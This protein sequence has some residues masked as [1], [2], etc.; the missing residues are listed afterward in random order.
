M[1]I[2]LKDNRMIFI[3]SSI[4]IAFV[5]VCYVA[6]QW[7][8][9]RWDVAPFVFAE[10]DESNIQRIQSFNDVYIG[11]DDPSGRS[12]ELVEQ[13]ETFEDLVFDHPFTKYDEYDTAKLKRYFNKATGDRKTEI[14][15][16][17][18]DQFD[19]AHDFMIRLMELYGDNKLPF[20]KGSEPYLF[21][22]KMVNS[23]TQFVEEVEDPFMIQAFHDLEQRITEAQQQRESDP[24][25]IKQDNAYKRALELVEQIESEINA[26]GYD[27]DNVSTNMPW[28]ISKEDQGHS[29][30]DDNEKAESSAVFDDLLSSTEANIVDIQDDK[31]RKHMRSDNELL[32][33]IDTHQNTPLSPE[34]LD[35]ALKLIDQYGSEEG[36]RRLRESDP[37]AARRFESDPDSIEDA[38]NRHKSKPERERR[39][40]PAHD[41]SDDAA[42]AQ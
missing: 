37:E 11:A 7:Y 33:E 28:V 36:L 42:S 14:A 39:N 12:K 17:I 34:Q 2:S 27:F 1:R 3:C 31:T 32:M 9:S 25:W 24:E 20:E 41:T 5:I 30:I 13:I 29:I 8:Y 19:N 10:N 23:Y 35:N 38:E 18:I 21:I 26:R 40:P 16:E 15:W 6:S 22:E 4:S